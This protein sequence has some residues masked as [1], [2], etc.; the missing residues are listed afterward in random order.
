MASP[1]S[2]ASQTRPPRPR[3]QGALWVQSRSGQIA[4]AQQRSRWQ[5]APPAWH[6]DRTVSYSSGPVGGNQ[7]PESEQ[8][9]GP[10][11]EKVGERVVGGKCRE[12]RPGPPTHHGSWDCIQKAVGNH[13]SDFVLQVGVPDLQRQILSHPP[14]D[15]SLHLNSVSPLWPSVPCPS[16]PS[17]R[18]LVTLWPHSS[19]VWPSPFLSCLKHA[20]P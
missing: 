9:K 5:L 1:D 17:P 8:W 2:L 11:T 19:H 16:S 4:H 6:I 18:S 15:F 3:M 20:F 12:V 10:G 7:L 13:L 14:H